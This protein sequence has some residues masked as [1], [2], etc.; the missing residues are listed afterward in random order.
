MGKFGWMVVEGL[1]FG[2]A[3][4]VVFRAVEEVKAKRGFD[5]KEV[6]IAAAALLVSVVGAVV[7]VVAS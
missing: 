1:L 6:G 7:M 4:L 3:L 5:P 2:L